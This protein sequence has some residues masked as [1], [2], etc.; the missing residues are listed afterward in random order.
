[1]IIED[2]A[3]VAEDIAARLDRAGYC[4]S[5]MVDN[6]ADAIT[7]YQR[8]RPDVVMADIHLKGELDGIQTITRIN[9]IDT[10]PVVYLTAYADKQTWERA[11]LTRPAAYLTKPFRDRD[12]HSAI[13]LAIAQRTSALTLPSP[14]ADSAAGQPHAAFRLDDRCFIRTATGRFEKLMLAD[15][16]YLKAERSYCRV[17]TRYGSIILSESLNQLHEKFSNKQL[18]RIHRSFVINAEAVDAIDR[19][20]VVINGEALP[21]GQSYESGFFSA[22]QLLR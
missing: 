10:T 12:I 9:T 15:L 5:A 13:E 18:I 14:V 1:M 7:A 19:N 20:T 22:I 17:V 6:G 21:I 11:K 4:I 3:I 8:L 16:L 2:E